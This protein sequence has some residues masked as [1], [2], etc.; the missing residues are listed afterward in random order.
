MSAPGSGQQ[1][2]QL[3]NIHERTQDLLSRYVEV[4]QASGDA[5][6][7]YPD[8]AAHLQDCQLCRELYADLA[9][10]VEP[11]GG[12]LIVGSQTRADVTGR[13]LPSVPQTPVDMLSR[14]EIILRV[15]HALTAMEQAEP[16]AG[17][18]L[19]YDTL[20]VGKLNLVATFTLHRCD[21][22]GLYR[23][24]GMIS[25]E[26]PAVRYK[27]VLWHMSGAREARIDGSHLM[28]DEISIDPE[29]S[30]MIVTLAIHSRWR[31]AGQEQAVILL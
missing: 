27:A 28:F 30:R 15:G 13:R 31:P 7:M 24:E 25:P 18:L 2:G 11:V 16:A 5:A 29:T 3:Q 21:Q 20:H 19:F 12:Q 4:Q 26:Q 8:I 1:S 10:T 17:C 9:S 14:E 6:G 22:A 23:I